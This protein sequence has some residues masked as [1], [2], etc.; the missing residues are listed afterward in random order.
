VKLQTKPCLENFFI[1]TTADSALRETLDECRRRHIKTALILMPEHSELRSW[2]SPAVQE[3]VNAYLA[4]LHSE[5]QVPIFDTREWVADEAFHDLTHMAP[6]AAPSYT[7]RL[8]RELLWP[9]LK[10]QKK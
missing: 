2:Y 8:G 9:W 4:R 1:S 5:Y 7:L 3:Q 6:P 10:S